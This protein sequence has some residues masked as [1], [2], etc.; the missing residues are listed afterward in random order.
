MAYASKHAKSRTKERL[1]LSKNVAD[2]NAERAFENGIGHRDCKG[3]L[4]RYVD[5]LYLRYRQGADYRVYNHHVYLFDV[6]THKLITI[7]DLPQSLCKLADKLQAKRK[8][9]KTCD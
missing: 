6:H 2:K 9:E 1:G 8:D 7:L 5:G 3:G 4:K